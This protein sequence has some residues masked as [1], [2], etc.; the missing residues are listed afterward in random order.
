MGG[1]I[2]INQFLRDFLNLTVVIKN[3]WSL[4]KSF[5]TCVFGDEVSTYVE[6][7]LYQNNDIEQIVKFLAF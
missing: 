1:K 3:I 5:R 7:L 2:L 4:I 6:N